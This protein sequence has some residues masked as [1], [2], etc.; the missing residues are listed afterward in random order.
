[1]LAERTRIPATMYLLMCLL[2]KHETTKNVACP[3]P[4]SEAA[5][6]LSWGRPHARIRSPELTTTATTTTTNNNNN[7]NTYDNENTI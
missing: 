6:Q 1:M 5:V 3:D 2:N 4:D 7:N